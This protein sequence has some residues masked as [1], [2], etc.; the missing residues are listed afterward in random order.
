MPLDYE[1]QREKC[2]NHFFIGAAF[3]SLNTDLTKWKGALSKGGL[4][5]NEYTKNLELKNEEILEKILDSIPFFCRDFFVA[6]KMERKSSR[7][8]VSYA[9]DIRTFINY[10]NDC[11]DIRINDVKDLEKL[12]ARDIE[13]YIASLSGT[14]SDCGTYRKLCCLHSFFGYFYRHGDISSN[15]SVLVNKIKVREKNIIYLEADEMSKLLDAVESGSLLAGKEKSYHSKT[16][17][18]DLAIITLFLGTGMRVSELVGL[19]TDDIDFESYS[20]KIT[21][22]GG[23]EAIIYFCDE[24]SEALQ[25]YIELERGSYN[26]SEESENALFLSLKHNRITVRAVENLVKKYTISVTPFKKITPHKLRSSFG[27]NLYTETSDIY[28][29]AEALGHKDVNTT[30]KHYAS[31]SEKRKESV[32]RNVTLREK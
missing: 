25:D 19:D 3:T 21:R 1:N 11:A 8:L 10:M 26:P 31:F 23:N 32:F 22:K 7:T 13:Y 5:L 14:T 17:Y 2:E 18:R 20:L 30:K 6:L 4:F 27:T 9:Y 29:V 16:K 24:V 28:A 12:S 15:P